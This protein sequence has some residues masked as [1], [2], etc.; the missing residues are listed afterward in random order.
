MTGDGLASVSS[1]TLATSL[2]LSATE[3]VPGAKILADPFSIKPE[4]TSYTSAHGVDYWFLAGDHTGSLRG[5]NLILDAGAS[6]SGTNG[7]VIIG[8][9]AREIQFGSTVTPGVTITEGTDHPVAPAATKAQ[10]WV[11]SDYVVPTPPSDYVKDGQALMMTTDQGTDINLSWLA[12]NYKPLMGTQ[13]AFAHIEEGT[14]LAGG[15]IKSFNVDSC[16]SYIYDHLSN[17]WYQAYIDNTVADARITS[18]SDG[19]YDWVTS[20]VVDTSIAHGDLAQPC[21]NGTNL[22]VAADGAFYLSTTL[23][24]TNLPSAGAPTGSPALMSGSTGLVWSEQASLWVMCGD[25]QTNGYIYTSPTGTTWTNRTPAGMTTDMPVSMD[26]AH[27]GFGG[28]SGTERILLCCGTNSTSIWYS[29][30]G[31]VSWTEDTTNVPTI[32]MET[33]MWAPSIANT[34]GSDMGVWIG[35]DASSNLW[36]SIDA[37]GFYWLDSTHSARCI[38]RTPEF[39][40]WGNTSGNCTWYQITTVANGIFDGIGIDGGSITWQGNSPGASSNQALNR[41]RYQWGNGVIMFDRLGDSE[42]VIGRY[43]PIEPLL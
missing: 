12:A 34:S 4:T 2:T 6:T 36:Y 41:A 30:N 27:T 43:G 17:M 7:I 33:V 11:K 28:F 23:S 10:V 1:S 9:V 8:E 31:G 24:A 18:S 38:Y 29:I 39:A 14:G 22:G 15:T 42:L 37:V 5:G 19:G 32:G 35:V 40:G 13:L 3:I 26:I 25:N 20:K 21:T 16:I